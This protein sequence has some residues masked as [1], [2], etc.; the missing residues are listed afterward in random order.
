MILHECI[1]ECPVCET[2]HDRNINAAI[3]IQHKGL[4]ESKGA[5]LIVQPIE[6]SVYTP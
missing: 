1:R 3:N 6:T 4:L 2:E 5:R